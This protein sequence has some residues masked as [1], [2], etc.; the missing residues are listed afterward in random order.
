MCGTALWVDGD[1]HERPNIAVSIT[2]GNWPFAYCGDNSFDVSPKWLLS[3][4]SPFPP[5]PPLLQH[6]PLKK[7]STIGQEA[8]SFFFVW[9]P[10]LPCQWPSL[11]NLD[12]AWRVPVLLLQYAQLPPGST[13]STCG[14]L[15]KI[16]TVRCVDSGQHGSAF[17]SETGCRSLLCFLGYKDRGVWS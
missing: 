8:S 9:A 17:Y 1:D 12:T 10:L 15:W 4:F 6:A 13:A 7:N 16:F 11:F 2:L 5:C 3:G 14:I